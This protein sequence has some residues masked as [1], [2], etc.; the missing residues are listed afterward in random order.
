MREMIGKIGIVVLLCAG[1]TIS[2]SSA[3]KEAAPTKPLAFEVVSIRQ[4]MSPVD[5]KRP[6]PPQFGPTADGYR[7]TDMPL[8]FAIMTAFPS[9]SAGAMFDPVDIA[10]VPDWAKHDGYDIEAKVAEEDLSKW[11]N[12]A[13]QPAMLRAML[14]TML[15]ERCRIVV[16]HEA[17]ESTVYFL[18]IG[19]NGPK[20]KET[21]PAKAHPAGTALPDGTTVVPSSSALNL[22]GASMSTLATVLSAIGKMEHPIQDRTGLAGRYDIVIPKPAPAAEGARPVSDSSDEAYSA[23]EALGLKLQSGKSNVE[24]LVIDHLE[25]PTAN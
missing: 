10:G 14:Q 21:D 11:Q 9:Q 19:K 13:L 22:Y 16:H 12:P 4:N 3:Q 23:V 6:G 20:L 5:V 7:M 8:V 2:Q 17:K 18:V 1:M 15:A 25:R 24:T